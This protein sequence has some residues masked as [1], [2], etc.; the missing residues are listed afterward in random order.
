[1]TCLGA[2]VHKLPLQA[3]SLSF[4]FLHFASP[5]LFAPLVPPSGT[6]CSA[7][8]TSPPHPQNPGAPRDDALDMFPA[9][10]QGIPRRA[11]RRC[12]CAPCQPRCAA[13][14][15][16]FMAYSMRPTAVR[17][18]IA[19]LRHKARSGGIVDELEK[20]STGFRYDGFT[21]RQRGYFHHRVELP[22]FGRNAR[23]P[24]T[25]LRS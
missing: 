22:V 3:T 17:A 19:T 9:D 14:P 1:M 15:A 23:R 25:R 24:H 8:A 5:H 12:R 10:R 4:Q 13:A 6:A 21:V 2:S 7:G 20:A 16:S 18:W 11:M